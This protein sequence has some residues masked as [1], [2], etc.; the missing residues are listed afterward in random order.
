MAEDET[1]RLGEL[2]A[3][4]GTSRLGR[5][6]EVGVMMEFARRGNGPA[7][8][9]GDAM[10]DMARWDPPSGRSLGCD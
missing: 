6:E 9:R 7:G 3:E 1:L 8:S 10:V 4:A 2:E 5:E